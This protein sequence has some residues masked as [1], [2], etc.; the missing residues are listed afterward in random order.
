MAMGDGGSYAEKG[1][2]P[3]WYLDNVRFIKSHM[4]GEA[5]GIWEHNVA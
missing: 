4:L 3:K 2:D 5:E 1:Y